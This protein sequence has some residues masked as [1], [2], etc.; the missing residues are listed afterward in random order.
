MVG[1]STSKIKNGHLFA[2][3]VGGWKCL[4]GQT[5]LQFV[6]NAR[7]GKAGD[8]LFVCNGIKCT[9]YGPNQGY[10]ESFCRNLLRTVWLSFGGDFSSIFSGGLRET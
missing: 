4:E 9:V 10:M 7:D 2:K 6:L 5:G 1:G 8:G 3:V